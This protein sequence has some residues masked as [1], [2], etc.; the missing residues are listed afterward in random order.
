MN[1]KTKF[2]TTMSLLSFVTIPISAI[3]CS[4][5]NLD[6]AKD[7]EG[8]KINNPQNLKLEN[9]ANVLDLK[10]RIS[11]HAYGDY[12]TSDFNVFS[13]KGAWHAY[14]LPAVGDFE[15]YGAFGGPSLVMQGGSKTHEPSESKIVNLA[16]FMNKVEIIN[17]Q[18]KSADGIIEP[19]TINLANAQKPTINSYPGRL[20]QSFMYSDYNEYKLNNENCVDYWRAKIELSL[21]FISS[22]SALIETKITNMGSYSENFSKNVKKDLDLN[23]QLKFNGSIYTTYWSDESYKKINQTIVADQNNFTVKYS[24]ENEYLGP[25]TKTSSF[26]SYFD[27]KISF[28]QTPNVN[29]KQIDYSVSLAEPVNI[30]T[31]ESFSTYRAES[32][33]FKNEELTK[34]KTNLDKLKNDKKFADEFNQNRKRWE[35]Y[36]NN[37]FKNVDKKYVNDQS[38]L[39]YIRATVK[40]IQTLITNW[41]SPAGDLKH[42]G[43]TPSISYRWFNGYWGWDSWKNAVAVAKF[44]KELAKEAIRV[45]YDYQVKESD[46]KL[47]YDK[48]AIVDVIYIDKS[49]NNLRNSKPPLSAWSIWN[50]ISADP[51][52]LDKEFAKEMFNKVMNYH[53]WWYTNRDH[54]QNGIAEYGAMNTDYNN[55]L[56]EKTK[57]YISG[58]P[59]VDE[60]ILAAAWESG[61]DNATRFDRYGFDSK[62][63]KL[64]EVPNDIY[65]LKNKDKNNNVIGYSINQ[66]S[67]DLNSYLYSEKIYLAKIANL[68]DKKS[69]EEKLLSDA[70]KVKDYINTYMFDK[71][72]GFYYDLYIN[73]DDNSKKTLLVD[74]G[75]GTEGWL[76]LW[77]Q[78]ASQANAEKVKNVIMNSEEFNTY[79]PFPTASKSNKKFSA[80]EYWRGPVWLDQ[81]LFGVEALQNYGFIDEARYMSFKLFNNAE[82][83]LSDESI[84]E[85]YNPLN[86]KGLH[87]KNFSW[88]AAAYYLLFTNVLA[89]DKNS[90]NQK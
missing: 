85:N 65:V 9:F 77:A 47:P 17:T 90:T 69:E 66:E 25:L 63:D 76:P 71:K 48:G 26:N 23:L 22:R 1:I 27:K 45:M 86:G 21:I 51:N 59:N 70:A 36:L 15:Q 84:R 29:N 74:R 13:D 34:E 5:V 75:R 46:P 49:G 41:R 2:W 61:M 64:G 78:A 81:A 16:S 24:G 73:K 83:V 32:F 60:A 14:A 89:N 38:L 88:S 33:T 31:N 10:N 57:T 6:S 30:K 18:H 4:S 20:V 87:T 58:E 53:N 82:G 7:Y 40:M 72:T 37:T 52:N 35:N 42:S 11:D 8:I 43:V 79:L 80:N 54:D 62:P 56:D 50:I 28:E 68:L 12:S 3:S 55:K 19:I 67:V 39:P 44:D